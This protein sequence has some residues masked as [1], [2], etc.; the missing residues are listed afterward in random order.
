MRDNCAKFG[1][2]NSPSLQILDKT[3]MI[4]IVDDIDMKLGPENKIHK[5]KKQHK[6]IGQWCHVGKF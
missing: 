1:I 6:K 5:R 3:Q 2:P 4:T